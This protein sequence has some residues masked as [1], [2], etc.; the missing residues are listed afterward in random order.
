MPKRTIKDL[1]KIH[2]VTRDQLNAAKSNGVDIWN[3]EAVKT[4]LDTKRHRIKPGAEMSEEVGATQTLAEI[5]EAIKRATNIDDVKI[6]KE[7]VLALKGI[8]SVQQETRQL[9]PT[10]EVR[11]EIVRCVSAA[12]A[13][14]MKITSD[15]PPRISGLSESAIQKILVDEMKRLLTNLSSETGCLFS[16]EP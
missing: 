6:L 1:L 8:V 4:W 16:E 13:E 10:S 14:M 3:D 12:R 15:L 9:V 2:G 5:E 11:E 7:K